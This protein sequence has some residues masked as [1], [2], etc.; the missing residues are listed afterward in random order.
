ASFEDDELEPVRHYP[1]G[2]NTGG[3]SPP[4]HTQ[5]GPV[6]QLA[7]S[8]SRCLSRA[9]HSFNCVA[10]AHPQNEKESFD[11]NHCWRRNRMVFLREEMKIGDIVQDS[12][13]LRLEGLDLMSARWIG[14]SFARHM[15]DFFAIRGAKKQ[16]GRRR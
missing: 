3:Q 5:V 13:C 8:V 11:I 14:H 1:G 9:G 15:H 12:R 6:D 2:C 10:L 4:A 7:P 16:S